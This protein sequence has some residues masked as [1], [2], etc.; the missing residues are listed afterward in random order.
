MVR[1]PQRLRRVLQPL[2][3]ASRDVR[4]VAAVEFAL[5]LPIMLLLFFGAN[6]LGNALTISRKVTH[7]TSTL[8]DLV[9]QAKSVSNTDMSNIL[10]V[11]S[12]IMRPYSTNHL[13]ARVSLIEVGSDNKARVRWSDVSN[14]GNAGSSAEPLLTAIPSG[15]IVTIPDSVKVNGTFLVS[16]EV[17]YYY[18]PTIGYVMTGVFDLDDQFYLSPRLSDR[19]KRPPSYNPTT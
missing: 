16:A 1:L 4:G 2:R 12:A 17:H 6:E 8:A 10:D 18:T 11:G 14:Y 9:A 3:R 19:V 7:L 13:R 15:T 5:I